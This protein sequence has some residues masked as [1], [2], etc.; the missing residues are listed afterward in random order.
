MKFG[1]RGIRGALGRRSS[2]KHAGGAAPG[3][4]MGEIYRLLLQSQ[5]GKCKVA[6]DPGDD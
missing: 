2:V 4:P 5:K 3:P 6:K 1:F